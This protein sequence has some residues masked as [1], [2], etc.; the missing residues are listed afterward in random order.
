MVQNQTVKV[1]VIAASVAL[2]AACSATGESVRSAAAG[3]VAVHDGG[4]ADEAQLQDLTATEAAIEGARARGPAGAAPAEAA[5]PPPVT[6]D[7]INPTAPKSYTVKRGDT[8]WDISSMFLKDPWL[9]PEIWYVNPQVENPH[10]IY[11]GDVLTL[12]YGADGRPQIRLTRGGM[13]GDGVRLEPRLRSSPG[14]SPIATIPY[15]AIAAFLS[16][17][18]VLAAEQ[19]KGAPHVVAFRNEHMI[20]GT[21]TEAYVS[22]LAAPVSSRFSVVHVGEALRDPDDGAVVGFM[23]V[24]AATA[25]VTKPGDPAKTLL[26][27][28]AR[29]TL[30]GDKLFAAEMDAPLNFV[31][32]APRNQVRGQIISVVDGVERIGA[33]QVVVINRGKRHGVDAGIVLAVDQAGETVRDRYSGDS[34]LTRTAFGGRQVKLPDERAGTLLVFRSYDRISYAL[35][36]GAAAPMR[37]GDMVRNP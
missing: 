34:A 29:E 17:P 7:A 28:S 22:G 6:A 30:R 33:W 26:S 24:Y 5:V 8:L 27:D 37:V 32:R 23:G 15:G 21:G 10:L 14:D 4:A 13:S 18:S 9:W 1:A 35:M 12:A 19:V 25:M 31:P 36:V 20:G 16:R 2:L 11:P 3:P